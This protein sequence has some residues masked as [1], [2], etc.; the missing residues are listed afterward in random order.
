MLIK[1]IQEGN[2]LVQA[3]GTNSIV[4]EEFKQ[5]YKGYLPKIHKEKLCPE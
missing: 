5:T 1:A 4:L 2:R 3:N